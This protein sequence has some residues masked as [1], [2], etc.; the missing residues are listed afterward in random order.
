[1][2]K[3]SKK[4]RQNTWLSQLGSY[5]VKAIPLRDWLTIFL[6][7]SFFFGVLYFIGLRNLFETRYIDNYTAEITDLWVDYVEDEMGGFQRYNA[8]MV[9]DEKEFTCLVSSPNMDIWFQLEIG[10][11]YN[12]EV[13][14]LGG[15]CSI[16]NVEEIV[17][18]EN[19][20]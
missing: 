18:I 3:P 17:A 13:M 14:R 19:Q 7:L 1:M 12:F 2:A 16:I 10:Q 4:N 6:F 9:K 20:P 8:Q 15:M 5:E 11:R